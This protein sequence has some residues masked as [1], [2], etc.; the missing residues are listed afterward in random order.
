MQ[1][2]YIGH[3]ILVKDPVMRRSRCGFEFYDIIVDPVSPDIDGHMGFVIAIKVG[4]L[5]KSISMMA[6]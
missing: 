3:A 1:I 5:K 2:R 6:M 4:V